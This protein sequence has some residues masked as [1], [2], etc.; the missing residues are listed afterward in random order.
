MEKEK[1]IKRPDNLTGARITAWGLVRF[2]NGISVGIT[3]EQ[4]KGLLQLSNYELLDE[5]GEGQGTETIEGSGEDEKQL[6]PDE[7][8]RVLEI[9][10]FA[11]KHGFEDV[12]KAKGKKAKL[13]ALNDHTKSD[14]E[15]DED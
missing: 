5:K 9:D 12:L 13:E 3:P 7:F 4:R 11:E 1:E 10:Q 15:K 8:W 6:W 14:L 2:K